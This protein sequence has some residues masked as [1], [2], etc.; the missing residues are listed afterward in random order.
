MNSVQKIGA[1]TVVTLAV[2]INVAWA[3]S[4][5][6]RVKGVSDFAK[7]QADSGPDHL[8]IGLAVALGCTLLI[9]LGAAMRGKRRG[10][11]KR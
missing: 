10:K 1:W 11:K 7:S 5:G 6:D 3:A 8:V 4:P 2:Q 9:A